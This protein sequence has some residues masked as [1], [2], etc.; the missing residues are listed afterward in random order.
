MDIT[1]LTTEE[2]ARVICLLGC[3]QD[4]NS[5]NDIFELLWEGV[6]GIKPPKDTNSAEYAEWAQDIEKQF[7]E[8]ELPPEHLQNLIDELGL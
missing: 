2:K 6:K 5:I 3:Q 8:L 1:T 4:D 7:N